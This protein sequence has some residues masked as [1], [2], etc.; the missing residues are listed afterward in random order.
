M[1]L[2]QAA[3]QNLR[4]YDGVAVL[5]VVDGIDEGERA[6]DAPGAGGP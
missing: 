4:E 2:R 3:P 5:G 6:L 1:A